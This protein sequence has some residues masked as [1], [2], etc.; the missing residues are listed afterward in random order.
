MRAFTVVGLAALILIV[1]TATAA[2][3]VSGRNEPPESTLS[4]KARARDVDVDLDEK[5]ALQIAEI[6]LVK[7]YGPEVLEEKPWNVTKQGDI[8]RIRGTLT[9]TLGGVAEIEINRKNAAVVSVIHWK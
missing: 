7:V 8:F 4:E 6:V 9:T 2:I 5:S 1:A 3:M